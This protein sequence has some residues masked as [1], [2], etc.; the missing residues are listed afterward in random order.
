MASKGEY[1]VGLSGSL[2][3]IDAEFVDVGSATQVTLDSK[4]IRTP[5]W[6]SN[7]AFW[8]RLP[9]AGQ[10]SF[11]ARLDWAFRSKTY[12]DVFNSALAVQKAFSLFKLFVPLL[13]ALLHILHRVFCMVSDCA[14]YR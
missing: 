6:T 5:A 10:S 3:Y 8:Y 7:L 1:Q 11:T 12:N 13:G 2:S 4:L 9:L 14:I